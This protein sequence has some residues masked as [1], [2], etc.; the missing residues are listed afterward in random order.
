M[1]HPIERLRWVARAE[2]AGATILTREAASA[3]ASVGDD[4]P[5]LVTGCRRVIERHPS[6]GPLWWLAARLLAA[7]DPIHE[8]WLASADLDAD[9]TPGVLA[10]H[11]PDDIT[12]TVVGWPELSAD[13]LRKRGDL[14]VLVVDARNEGPHFVRR[15]ESAGV[16]AFDVPE[17]GLG[18]AVKEADLVLLEADALGASGFAGACGSLAAAA[19]ARALGIDV[20]VVAGAGRVLPQRLWEALVKRVGADDEPW[21]A[22]CDI[23]PLEWATAVC[24][25]A[26]PQSPADAIKRADC[27]IAPELLRWD[28]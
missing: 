20:W 14:E 10:A 26:G 27:P 21:D 23:V 1:P 2:G 7:D 5:A 9:E 16:A 19:T 11:F 15:L 28:A 24:G 25:P 18:A 12:V 17:S 3:L 4:L 13:A 22:S 8:A 6:I